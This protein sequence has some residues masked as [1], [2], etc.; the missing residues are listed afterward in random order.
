MTVKGLL[1]YFAVFDNTSIVRDFSESLEGSRTVCSCH[2]GPEEGS[3]RP[4]PP[5]DRAEALSSLVIH[6]TVRCHGSWHLATSVHPQNLL[7]KFGE[8]SG[9]NWVGCKGRKGSPIV[10]ADFPCAS[11]QHYCISPQIRSTEKQ[12]LCKITFATK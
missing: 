11:K 4:C 3:V 5:M 9:A 1:S 12:E 6:H 2:A 7:R 8:S 10:Q